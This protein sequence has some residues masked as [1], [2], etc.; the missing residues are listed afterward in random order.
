MLK[1]LMPELDQ[2]WT[3]A[4]Q[5]AKQ[6]AR[7]LGRQDILDY[8]R[9]REIND[10][11]RIVGMKWLFSTFLEVANEA[12][13]RGLK[14]HIEQTEQHQFQ[15]NAA[16]MRGARVQLKQGVRA[17]TIE[18]GYPRQPADGFVRGGG[19]AA[20]RVTHFGLAKA[21][22]DLLLVRASN[23]SDAPIW[24]AIDKDNLRQPFSTAY[25]KQHFAVF[26]EQI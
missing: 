5:T 26:L 8:I 24:F 22:A 6:R 21:N 12:N 20:A 2:M 23:E 7:D 14:L 9:L 19:L 10:E 1:S 15:I 18:A 13:R 16:T 11:A 17:L 3:D 4:L 25:L